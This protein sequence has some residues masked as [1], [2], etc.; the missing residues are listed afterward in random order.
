MNYIN[1]I[2]RTI[3]FFLALFITSISLISCKNDSAKYN[4]LEI[5]NNAL[6]Q[7][8]GAILKS[9]GN[10]I[11]SLIIFNDTINFN[12]VTIEH[13]GEKWADKAQIYKGSSCIEIHFPD[14]LKVFS[15]DWPQPAISP[16]P[17]HTNII[18]EANSYD[19]DTFRSPIII[20]MTHKFRNPISKRSIEKERT[21]DTGIG[22]GYKKDGKEI[23][24]VLQFHCKARLKLKGKFIKN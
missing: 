9:Y 11:D 22:I 13:T 10:S 16:D 24:Y 7:E 17:I 21:Y 12:V 23:Y 6:Q 5:H 15:Y 4:L 18:S 20:E 14:S 8:R 3:K 1:I 19:D 2:Q